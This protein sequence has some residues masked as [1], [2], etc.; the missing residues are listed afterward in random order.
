MG[1]GEFHLRPDPCNNAGPNYECAAHTY[2]TLLGDVRLFEISLKTD[3]IIM[4]HEMANQIREIWM[5]GRGH[6]PATD[7]FYNGHSIGRWDSEDLVVESTNFTF[8]PDGMDD[9][10]H[11]P[12]SVRKKLT[13][14]YTLTDPDTLLITITLEDSLFLTEPFTWTHKWVRTDEPMDG[15]WDCDPEVTRREVELN[16]IPKYAD[17]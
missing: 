3:S 2:P 9:Y 10:A 13:E 6:P 14:R 12:T 5:D 17:D 16:Y 15:W 7:L 8:D 1:K 4:N 11:L